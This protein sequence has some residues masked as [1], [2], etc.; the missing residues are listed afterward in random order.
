MCTVPNCQCGESQNQPPPTLSPPL[1]SELELNLPPVENWSPISAQQPPLYIQPAVLGRRRSSSSSG[2]RP[3]GY[4]A[5]IIPNSASWVSPPPSTS[6]DFNQQMPRLMQPFPQMG[7]TPPTGPGFY[8]PGHPLRTTPPYDTQHPHL[9]QQISSQYNTRRPTATYGNR[10]VISY[11]QPHYDK[12]M[13]TSTTDDT[14]SPSSEDGDE[15][16]ED[17]DRA[18]MPPPKFIPIP[19]HRPSP[20]SSITT[21]PSANPRAQSQVLPERDRERGRD[22]R[23]FPM[24]F[25]KARL[26]PNPSRN[27]IVKI[28][29]AIS[30]R[31]PSYTSH[32]N[33]R[34][35]DAKR[36]DTRLYGGDIQAQQRFS[37]TNLDARR[38]ADDLEAKKREVKIY[39]QRMGH[40]NSTPALVPLVKKLRCVL[41]P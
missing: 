39:P 35:L 16:G 41:M 37:P 33:R 23:A 29:S 10:P 11:G 30:R 34:E 28:E 20:R 14:S 36:W 22:P 40:P 19:Q 25:P 15:Y 12:E 9:Q 18:L 17:T 32:E 8:P 3:V 13:S 27:P 1:E 4:H 5:S 6:A 7:A 38:Y 2:A 24:G 21:N 31:Q 26:Y